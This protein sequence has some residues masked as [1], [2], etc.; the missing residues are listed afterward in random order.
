VQKPLS[1]SYEYIVIGSGAGGGPLA[2][3]LALAGKRTLLIEAGNDQGGN[4]NYEI[5]THHPIVAEDSALSWDYYVTHYKDPKEQVRDDKMAWWSPEGKS[6]VGHTAPAGSKQRGIFYPRSGTL[7]GCTAH[8]AMV[9]IYP[10]ARDWEYIQK[11]TGDDSWHPAKM[12]QL[13]AKMERNQYASA[14]ANMSG[15]GTDGWLTL[16]TTDPNL[17]ADDSQITYIAMGSVQTMAKNEEEAT[18]GLGTFMTEDLNSYSPER[19]EKEGLFFIPLSIKNGRRAGARDI[20]LEVYNAKTADGKKKYPLDIA[21]NTFATKLLFSP[22][23]GGAKP[24]ATGVEYLHGEYLFNASPR[25]NKNSAGE[26]GKVTAEKEIIVSAGTF[27]TPHLLMLSGIGPKAE[28]EQ[29]KIPVVADLP[30]VGTN[31]QDHMEIGITHE[32]PSEFNVSAG[33]TLAK[34]NDPCVAKWKEGKG[35]YT[36]SN[37]FP[38]AVTKKT[39]VADQDKDFAGLPDVILFGGPANFAGYYP[40]YSDTSFDGKNFTWVVLR[41]HTANNA[42]TVSLKSTNPREMPAV[43][44]NFFKAGDKV[45]AERDLTAMAESVELGRKLTSSSFAQLG[46]DAVEKMPGV[47]IQSKDDLKQHI[48]DKAWSHHAS[49]TAAIGADG[50][51]MA[52]L[53]SKFRVRGVDGLRVVDASIWPRIPGYFVVVPTYMASEKAAM[54]ILKG[55]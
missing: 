1:D 47:H 35:I 23:T 45:A 21:L 2:A 32:F 42:G 43:D 26:A 38:Y 40:G 15:H 46:K 9:S 29:F 22:A 49:G 36:Q 5:P 12:R 7:G 34:A 16:T 51:K 3:R 13:F 24:K 33:C 11:L 8:N 28:L 44:L 37:G 54:S 39:S 48:A 53:D 31:L 55:E 20:I 50:N 19:D 4:L 10:H 52:V 6:V 18:M 14:P 27:N 30:G 17:A 25:Y 41:A